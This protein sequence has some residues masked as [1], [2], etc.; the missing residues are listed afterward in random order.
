MILLTKNSGASKIK[1]NI[2]F[3]MGLLKSNTKQNCTK[4]SVHDFYLHKN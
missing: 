1:L 2:K 3:Y 4:K